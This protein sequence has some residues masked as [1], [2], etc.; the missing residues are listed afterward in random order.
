MKLRFLHLCVA[1]LLLAPSSK[2][3]AAETG[4]TKPVFLY[5]RYFN[6]PG[7]NRYLPD[8]NYK[9]VMMRLRTEF[10]VRANAEPL[11]RKSLADENVLLIANPSDKASGTN[12]P[13]HHISAA[14]A[15]TIARFVAQGGG[16][17]IMANQEGHNVEIDDVNKLLARFGL[18]FTNLYT[19]VKSL[20]LPKETPVIGGLRW[21]YY[22]GNLVLI[23]T[24]HAAKPRS[25]INNDITQKP[26][27][28]PRNKAGSLL[29]V[30][31]PGRGHVVVVTDCGWLTNDVLAG[32][33]I[34]G[35]VVNHDDN[36]EIFRRLALWASGR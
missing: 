32:E 7:E 20:L 15:K 17:I 8:G 16:L 27:N 13:P 30:A 10:K 5:T 3:F 21:G 6:A 28:G 36:W 2:S 19:D 26:L 23:E 14:D 34:G 22:T 18:Q 9:D 4:A 11:T 31:E 12:P 24:N 33:G 35:T 25:L 29:A 1:V